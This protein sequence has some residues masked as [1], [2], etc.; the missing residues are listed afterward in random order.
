MKDKT[1]QAQIDQTLDLSKTLGINGTPTLIVGEKKVLPGYVSAE[2][3]SKLLKEASTSADN[4]AASPSKKA[5]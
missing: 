1:I 2:E 4:K 3:L 5:G